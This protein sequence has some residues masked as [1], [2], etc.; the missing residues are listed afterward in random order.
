M[1][2]GGRP[3]TLDLVDLQRCTL[4]VCERSAAQGR[5][6]V[7]ELPECSLATLPLE[8]SFESDWLGTAVL[9]GGGAILVRPDGHVARVVPR[10][11]AQARAALQASMEGLGFEAAALPA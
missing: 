2:H 9:R 6:T 3:A 5:A 4:L 7:A 1:V 10:C 8:A 11:D